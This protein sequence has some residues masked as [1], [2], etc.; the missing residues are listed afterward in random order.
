MRPLTSCDEGLSPAEFFSPRARSAT[1]DRA[2]RAPRRS[3][4]RP[5][6]GGNGP[7]VHA[8]RFVSPRPAPPPRCPPQR[9]RPAALGTCSA[10]RAANEKIPAAKLCGRGG[11]PRTLFCHTCNGSQGA[12]VGVKVPGVKTLSAGLAL[13]ED[14]ARLRAVVVLLL[15][16][17]LVLLGCAVAA[18]RARRL[19]AQRAS[20]GA[21]LVRARPGGR[22]PQF[23]RRRR[24]R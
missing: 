11:L 7:V 9:S 24:R 14:A 15:L 1:Q 16:L 3:A 19:L 5:P 20:A 8:R 21:G 10:G 2:V 13:V 22:G 12:T 18:A 23:R 4:P 17:V 6:R